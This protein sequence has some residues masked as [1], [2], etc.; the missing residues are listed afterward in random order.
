MSAFFQIAFWIF[1]GFVWINFNFWYIRKNIPRNILTW[2]G[3]LTYTYLWVSEYLVIQQ[4][5]VDQGIPFT[6]FVLFSPV[7]LFLL[8]YIV[9]K[10][11]PRLLLTWLGI[12]SV[13]LFSAFLYYKLVELR[14][15]SFW[16]SLHSFLVSNLSLSSS[17]GRW[18]T[19]VIIPV[20][21][22]ISITLWGWLN[23][24]RQKELSKKNTCEVELRDYFD[25]MYELLSE[26]NKSQ[27]Q[28][29]FSDQDELKSLFGVAQIRTLS[30]SQNLGD[31]T[32]GKRRVV[33][34]L[35]STG[36]LKKTEYQLLRDADM[37][38]SNLE[39]MN[40][41]GANLSG[42]IFHSSSFNR[43][44]LSDSDLS[45]SNFEG[46]S[47]CESILTSADCRNSSFERAK[48]SSTEYS[49]LNTLRRG[50]E[51]IRLKPANLKGANFENANLENADLFDVEL[52]AV[53][54][55]NANLKEAR[56]K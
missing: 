43:A 1:W 53:N 3:G 35:Y 19:Q 36:L 8:W 17:F 44:N 14:A 22:P 28:N 16:D 27:N 13:L 31:Y 10:L 30:I 40:L 21:I 33:Q 38:S 52:T 6:L 39:N 12:I 32:T 48:F 46:C 25:R 24:Q 20:S 50:L 18:L 34:F 37:S 55:E 29:I 5:L 11:T 47:F 4:I 56:I 7:S 45:C 23:E 15:P 2:I 9:L 54:L 26:I 42:A 49:R 41:S 51:W